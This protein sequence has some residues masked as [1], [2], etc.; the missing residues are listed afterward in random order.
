MGTGVNT[1]A[2]I[3]LATP[4]PRPERLERTERLLRSIHARVTPQRLIVLDALLAR[5]GHVTA[6]DLLHRVV[7]AY[8]AI[9]LAT[10]YRVLDLLIAHGL[11]AR[12]SLG[13]SA[14]TFEFVGDRLHHH[15]ICQDCGAVTECADDLVLPVRERLL[16]ATGFQVAPRP[17]ALV[18]VC[19]A[20]QRT[21]SHS[22]AI[23]VAAE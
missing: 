19:P 3:A 14:G 12:T 21:Q 17:L 4:E 8:P 11:V 15:L 16:R 1:I 23:P 5:P 18:G 7:A 9:N 22:G 10:I 2:D 20:C 6:D 13:G